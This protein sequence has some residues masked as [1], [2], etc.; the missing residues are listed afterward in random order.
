MAA[1]LLCAAGRAH[2]RAVADVWERT[3]ENWLAW[4]RYACLTCTLLAVARERS[5]VAGMVTSQPLTRQPHCRMSQWPRHASPCLQW[6][7]Q[8]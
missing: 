3:M 8:Q 5:R 1:A 4:L 7:G 6:C 2:H